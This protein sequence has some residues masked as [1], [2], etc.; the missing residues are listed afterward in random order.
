MK[1]SYIRSINAQ[2]VISMEILINVISAFFISAINKT[3]RMIN[4]TL[5]RRKANRLPPKSSD[6]SKLYELALQD[7]Q[8]LLREHEHEQV[9]FIQHSGYMV[10]NQIIS[11]LKQGVDV[12]LYQQEPSIKLLANLPLIRNRITQLPEQ[13]S[14]NYGNVRYRGRLTVKR[15]TSPASL[16]V[17]Y[18]RNKL[19]VLSWYNYYYIG[20]ELKIAGSENPGL[21]LT[22]SDSDFSSYNIMVNEALS[23]YD[24]ESSHDAEAI[25]NNIFLHHPDMSFEQSP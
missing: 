7:A 18:I 3:G 23:S 2:T 17:L 13:I 22:N 4:R 6:Q 25:A 5:L 8:A 12:V 15:F 24:R 1:T 9:I 19:L 14:V 16:R 11:L 20:G 21:L 10:A